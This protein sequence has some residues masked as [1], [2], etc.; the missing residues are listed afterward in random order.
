[1]SRGREALEAFAQRWLAAHPDRECPIVMPEWR[2]GEPPGTAALQDARA[3]ETA[4]AELTADPG[5]AV[6]PPDGLVVLEDDERPHNLACAVTLAEE[7]DNTLSCLGCPA[8]A[9][10]R[11]KVRAPFDVGGAR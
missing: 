7:C 9:Q 5:V 10:W 2:Y 8:Y 4:L 1:M 3:L 6:L 11:A